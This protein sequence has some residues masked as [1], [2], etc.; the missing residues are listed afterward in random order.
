M[1]PFHAAERP[2]RA[3]LNAGCPRLAAACLALAL[4]A[5]VSAGLRGHAPF[6]EINALRLDG[7]SLE[8]DLGLRNPNSVPILISNIR[9]TVD[10]EE[11]RLVA[12]D[13]PS[14][15]SVLANGVENLRFQVTASPEGAALLRELE[16]GNRASLAYRLEGTIVASE[17]ETM[18]LD[19]RGRLYPV[20]GRPGQFR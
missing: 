4:G 10:L 2:F 16:A 11:T 7:T 19:R 8:L 15:A 17:D 14:E 13:S 3:A 6:T 12:Y 5:C 18:K 20:P 9:F 1:N